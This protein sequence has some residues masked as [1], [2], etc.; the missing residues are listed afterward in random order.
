[1]TPA[2]HLSYS[3]HL[4]LG[5]S[6]GRW[7][8][9]HATQKHRPWTWCCTKSHN[10]RNHRT[11][12]CISRDPSPASSLLPANSPDWALRSH[13]SG[14][15]PRVVSTQQRWDDLN[16]VSHKDGKQSKSHTSLHLWKDAHVALPREADA[17][18]RISHRCPK[19]YPCLLPWCGT[20]C[21][22]HRSIHSAPQRSRRLILNKLRIFMHENSRKTWVDI[23]VMIFRISSSLLFVLLPRPQQRTQRGSK[24]DELTSDSWLHRTIV[25]DPRSQVAIGVHKMLW[26]D[27]ITAMNE[28]I[29]ENRNLK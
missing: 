15:H 20:S 21:L 28:P 4:G 5:C 29:S 7:R 3:P 13:S 18:S 27:L 14:W 26:P 11:L 6:L 24:T 2:S 23:I 22:L 19:L 10:S 25:T 1:M 16:S 17:T 9:R 12:S 8:G